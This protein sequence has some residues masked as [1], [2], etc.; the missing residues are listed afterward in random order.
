M[1][2]N[3]MNQ[4][5]IACSLNALTD[6]ERRREGELL[7]LHLDSIRERRERDDGYSYRYREDPALFAQIAELVG[8]EHRCCPFLD[9]RLEWAGAEST[10][11]LHITGGARVKPFVAETFGAPHD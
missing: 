6:Q 9:F 2:Q 10:P 4:L 1:E 11:R 8:L 7:E 5:P 3:D